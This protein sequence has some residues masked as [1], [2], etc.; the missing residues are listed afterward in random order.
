MFC[1]GSPAIAVIKWIPRIVLV[2]SP[3][4]HLQVVD[5]IESCERSFWHICEPKSAAAAHLESSMPARMRAW[6]PRMAAPRLQTE[7]LILVTA[8]PERHQGRC[9]RSPLTHAHCNHIV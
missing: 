5:W 8:R 4:T 7:F 6:P 9:S 2:I 3:E 1:C